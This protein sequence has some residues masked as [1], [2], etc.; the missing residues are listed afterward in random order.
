MRPILGGTQ[1][2][3][4]NVNELYA[5][6]VVYAPDY[7]ILEISVKLR[8]T[9]IELA[10]Q[11]FDR[12]SRLVEMERRYAAVHAALLQSVATPLP[13]LE[14]TE[15]AHQLEGYL[16]MIDDCAGE[17]IEQAEK[18]RRKMSAALGRPLNVL[19]I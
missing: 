17:L 6:W 16:R 5:G 13:C 3:F 10:I 18:L 2:E 14:T 15:L 11:Y 19:D 8:R 12:W 7:P 1:P 4:A 9:E